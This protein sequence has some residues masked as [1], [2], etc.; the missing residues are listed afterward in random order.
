MAKANLG[1][2]GSSALL[3]V[4]GLSVGT[5]PASADSNGLVT[6][7]GIVTDGSGAPVSGTTVGLI[8]TGG[9]RLAI[10]SPVSA[11]LS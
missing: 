11:P 9:S 6:L 1:V 2:A 8:T 10:G 7:S 4:G 5:T 3:L